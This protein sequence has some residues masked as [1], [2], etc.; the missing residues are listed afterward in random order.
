MAHIIVST[1][2]FRCSPS[3]VLSSNVAFINDK[4]LVHSA[5]IGS[6]SVLVLGWPSF[7][8]SFA[9]HESPFDIFLRIKGIIKLQMLL[10]LFSIIFSI[11]FQKKKKL[12]LPELSNGFI[13]PVSAFCFKLVHDLAVSANF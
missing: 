8:N 6:G 2:F 10:F 5:V 12:S 4:Y 7:F 1:W 3:D 9:S 11:V 13:G